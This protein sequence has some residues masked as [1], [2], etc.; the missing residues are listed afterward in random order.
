MMEIFQE[1]ELNFVHVCQATSVMSDSAT[2]WTVDSSGKN[3]RVGCHVLFQGI[4]LSWTEPV[5][6]SCIPALAGRFS[7]TSATWEFC[8]MNFILLQQE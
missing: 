5:R 3:T 1:L 7:I 4:V 6:V 8:A 2:L